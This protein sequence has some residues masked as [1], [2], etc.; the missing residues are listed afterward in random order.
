MDDDNYYLEALINLRD[1]ITV[2]EG[3]PDYAGDWDREVAC[4]RPDVF[5]E[6]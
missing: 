6:E 4:V 3:Y 1:E 5:D 2:E